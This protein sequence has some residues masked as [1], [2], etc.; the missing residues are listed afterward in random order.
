MGINN[1]GAAAGA[2]AFVGI[3]AGA[4]AR[5]PCIILPSMDDKSCIE[6]F[7]GLIVCGS[8]LIGVA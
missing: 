1:V 8:W 7:K 4:G 2:G 3:G 5:V 6:K